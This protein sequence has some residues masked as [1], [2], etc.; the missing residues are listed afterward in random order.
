MSSK[1]LGLASDEASGDEVGDDDDLTF[2]LPFLFFFFL[3]DLA[4]RPVLATFLANDGNLLLLRHI[5]VVSLAAN[6]FFRPRR[7]SSGLI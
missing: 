1:G 2:S 5:V 4:P 3:D 6:C 7:S